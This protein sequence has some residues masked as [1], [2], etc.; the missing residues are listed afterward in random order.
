ML[1]V[2]HVL[3]LNLFL[4][5]FLF[6]GGLILHASTLC[7][8]LRFEKYQATLEKQPRL[9]WGRLRKYGGMQKVQ[10]PLEFVK[11]RGYPPEVV[12]KVNSF[13]KTCL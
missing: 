11:P 6:A 8:N 10:L 3:Y 4:C 2:L 1:L 9:P 12:Q 7:T 13:V 5:C